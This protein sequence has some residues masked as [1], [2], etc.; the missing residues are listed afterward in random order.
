[1]NGRFH[2]IERRR[3]KNKSHSQKEI[4][5]TIK[6]NVSSSSLFHDD[7]SLVPTGTKWPLV[8]DIISRLDEAINGSWDSLH[9]RIIVIA[10]LE[11]TKM[12]YLRPTP[13]CALIN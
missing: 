6:M 5:K 8:I 9:H 10:I 12:L 1:M 3:I 7:Y 2:P 11:N 13:F 4:I